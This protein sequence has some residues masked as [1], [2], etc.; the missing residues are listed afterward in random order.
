MTTKEYA[1]L[2][3]KTIENN[4]LYGRSFTLGVALYTLLTNGY[5]NSETNALVEIEHQLAGALAAEL[6]AD[7]QVIYNKLSTRALAE[8]VDI[9]VLDEIARG[10]SEEVE[11]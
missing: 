5:F 9:A 3:E 10:L 7:P 1:Q 8:A 2:F 4:E 6:E 11:A